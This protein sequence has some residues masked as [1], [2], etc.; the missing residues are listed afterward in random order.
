[1][2][3]QDTCDQRMLSPIRLR[4]EKWQGR[5]MLKRT[6]LITT[7]YEGQD[8]SRGQLGAISV[9]HQD[10][11]VVPAT[12][13]QQIAGVN[14]ETAWLPDAR[15]CLK[16][17]DHQ[18]H[19]V[20]ISVSHQKCYWSFWVRPRRRF[21]WLVPYEPI[22]WDQEPFRTK[23]KLCF[24]V[25]EWRASSPLRVPFLPGRLW[26]G[27]LHGVQVLGGATGRSSDSAGASLPAQC[28]H[29]ARCRHSHLELQCWAQS[30]CTR[31]QAKKQAQLFGLGHSGLKYLVGALFT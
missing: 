21:S 31:S 27:Q 25:K 1:M 11:M 18:I 28:L 3:H 8:G 6:T 20:H 29:T 5:F 7:L 15:S 2:T 13:Y 9:R 16:F 30:F 4:V 12:G 14:S 19:P 17:T 22:E 26:A 24:S 23:G 10:V